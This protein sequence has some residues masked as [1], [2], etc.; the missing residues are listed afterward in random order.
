MQDALPSLRT[1]QTIVQSQEF[2]TLMTHLT[3][4]HAHPIV[5]VA[6]DAT[7]I[8]KRVEYDPVTNKCVGFVLRLDDDGNPKTN[9]CLATSFEA[10]EGMFSSI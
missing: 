3:K 5:T 10:I 8:V 1:I 2:D 9:V 6:E 7:R 4:H